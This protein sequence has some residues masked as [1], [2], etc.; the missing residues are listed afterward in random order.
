MNVPDDLKKLAESLKLKEHQRTFI[1]L[2]F[3]L[4]E[5]SVTEAYCQAY[6]TKNRKKRRAPSAGRK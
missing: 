5:R 6:G 3:S 2:C 4:P 1:E